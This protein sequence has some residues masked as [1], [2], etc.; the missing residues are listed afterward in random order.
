MKKDFQ[1]RLLPFGV[2][3]S[4]FGLAALSVMHYLWG[5]L[6]L[7]EYHTDIT[8]TLMWADA[9]YK[10]GRLVSPDHYY[11]YVIPFGGQ[12]LMLP[13][14][15]FFGAGITTLRL[16]MTVFFVLF[17][18]LLVVFF[19]RVAFRALP[20]SLTASGCMIL[21]FMYNKKLREVMYAHVIHYSLAIVLILL[22]CIVLAL[23]LDEKH[24]AKKRTALYIALGVSGFFC[25]ANG[26]TVLALSLCPVGMAFLLERAVNTLGFRHAWDSRQ[27][28][29][30]ACGVVIASALCGL[31]VYGLLSYGAHAEYGKQY[32]HLVGPEMWIDNIRSTVEQWI[33]IL[34]RPEL[35]GDTVPA[36]S[37]MTRYGSYMHFGL[38]LC[39]TA[40]LPLMLVLT[41]MRY[42]RL[43]SRTQRIVVLV[44]WMLALITFVLYAVTKLNFSSWRMIPM[45]FMMFAALAVLIGN[46]LE[47]DRLSLRRAGAVLAAGM[48]F[49]AV[50]AGAGVLTAYADKDVWFEEGSALDTILDHGLTHGFTN[51][52]TL[53]KTYGMLTGGEVDMSYI[54]VRSRPGK[55]HARLYQNDAADFLPQEDPDARYFV[56]ITDLQ[57]VHEPVG[58]TEKYEG[59]TFL[60]SY[61]S[62]RD[63]YTDYVIYVFD[64]YPLETTMYEDFSYKMIELEDVIKRKGD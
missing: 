31:A 10:S 23:L 17:S 52:Q 53:V 28:D 6:L 64:H 8:D 9:I 24:G 25:A 37:S 18:L 48:I 26:L 30:R 15:P 11:P 21:I 36:V 61:F 16:G 55:Y 40:A 2:G 32:M 22:L 47:D 12:L 50:H 56:L 14:I 51:T 63:T 1:K 57:N 27:E 45:L 62:W 54:Q 43:K 33:Q 44:F 38:K 4:V 42:G 41:V 35:F 13:F 58:Y 46:M 59:V 19:D 5:D 39:M 20:A 3:M 60:P 29:I 7:M 34:L 49:I